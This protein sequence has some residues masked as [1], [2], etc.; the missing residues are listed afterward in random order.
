MYS[1]SNTD[2]T[3]AEVGTNMDLYT[4]QQFKV[5]EIISCIARKT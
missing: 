1:M 5:S 2:D 3:A 4:Q